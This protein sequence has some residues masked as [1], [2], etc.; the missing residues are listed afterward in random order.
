MLEG[1]RKGQWT[2]ERLGEHLGMGSLR[3]VP[4][5]HP[6]RV[7]AGSRI[8]GP[9]AQGAHHTDHR[10]AWPLRKE[11]PEEQLQTEDTS[12]KGITIPSGELVDRQT[13]DPWGSA[14]RQP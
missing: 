10:N 7:T 6:S 4:L 9:G 14:L 3:L 8:C 11:T 12:Q 2:L 1:C 5:G 13:L